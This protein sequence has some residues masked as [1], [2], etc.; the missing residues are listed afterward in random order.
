VL[1][2]R[3]KITGVLPYLLTAALGTTN[4]PETYAGVVLFAIK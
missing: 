1:H 2:K 3:D 4:N